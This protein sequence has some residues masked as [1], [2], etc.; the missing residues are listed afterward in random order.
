MRAQERNVRLE[1]LPPDP[2]HLDR[3][4]LDDLTVEVLEAVETRAE[5]ALGAIASADFER[6]VIALVFQ[7]EAETFREVQHKMAA[8]VDVIAS[9]VPIDVERYQVERPDRPA[10]TPA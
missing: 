1:L 7:I 6:G 3:E 9:V 4:R 10:L 2:Q 5:D 8:I